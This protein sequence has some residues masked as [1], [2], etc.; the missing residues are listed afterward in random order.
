MKFVK[1]VTFSVERCGRAWPWDWCSV[2]HRKCSASLALWCWS[3]WDQARRKHRR[4][5][6][7]LTGSNLQGI[8]LQVERRYSLTRRTLAPNVPQFYRWSSRPLGKPARAGE[9]E[10]AICAG[11]GKWFLSA[12]SLIIALP[13]QSLTPSFCWIL[14]KLMD[15]PKLL[16]IVHIIGSHFCGSRGKRCSMYFLPIV[17][18]NQADV[19][20]LFQCLL[21]L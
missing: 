13:C 8:L 16:W 19:W 3:S 5:L 15:L 1:L 20:P 6:P 2:L 10:A 7:I 4:F 21:M 11:A 18:Q 9:I 17:K 14:L 12:R